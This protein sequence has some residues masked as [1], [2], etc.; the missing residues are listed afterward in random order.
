MAFAFKYDFPKKD[1]NISTISFSSKELA[2]KFEELSRDCCVFEDGRFSCLPLH[3]ITREGNNFSITEGK[4][5]KCN[6]YGNSHKR[7]LERKN[8]STMIKVKRTGNNSIEIHIGG[9][10]D[11]NL[12]QYFLLY[13]CEQYHCGSSHVWSIG[14][15]VDLI[16]QTEFYPCS[17]KCSFDISGTQILN[18]SSKGKLSEEKPKTQSSIIRFIDG[19]IFIE[20]TPTEIREYFQEMRNNVHP[21]RLYNVLPTE[22]TKGYK[23]RFNEE[24]IMIEF[25][26]YNQRGERDGFLRR[27]SHSGQLLKAEFYDDGKFVSTEF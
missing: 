19:N 11:F 23:M 16:T 26:Q 3:S 6:M 24:G 15:M 9:P 10:Q 17:S 18:L 27:F 22:T 13:G 2:D 7:T 12:Y 25:Y 20:E 4:I 1:V 14:K 21:L 8:L 5:H